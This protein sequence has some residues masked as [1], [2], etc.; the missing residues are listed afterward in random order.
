MFYKGAPY[1]RRTIILELKENIRREI[2]AIDV[3]ILQRAT[4]S[5][6]KQIADFIQ[7]GGGHLSNVI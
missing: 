4:D 3:H 5:M 2:T 7:N 6:K 1:S